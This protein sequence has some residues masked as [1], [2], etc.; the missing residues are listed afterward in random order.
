MGIKIVLPNTL[1]CAVHHAQTSLG[2]N[3]SLLGSNRSFPTRV[4]TAIPSFCNA[5]ILPCI[6]GQFPVTNPLPSD[7]VDFA[8][9]VE[10]VGWHGTIYRPLPPDFG[11][12]EKWSKQ[13]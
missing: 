8:D 12:Q 7:P 10:V 4:D 9:C 13:K 6:V 1:S 2:C 3:I 11:Y 5:A